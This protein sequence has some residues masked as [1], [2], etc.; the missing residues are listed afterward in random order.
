[1]PEL[2][3]EMTSLSD[4]TMSIIPIVVVADAHV[5]ASPCPDKSTKSDVS[6]AHHK[7]CH[8]SEDSSETDSLPTKV[9]C[10]REY[11]F[12]PSAASE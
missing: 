3:Q 12:W 6:A 8:T 9:F 11:K 4:L 1:M 10:S 2:S 5:A 7:R